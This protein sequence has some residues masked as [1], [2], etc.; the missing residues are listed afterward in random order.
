MPSIFQVLDA[1]RERPG[2]YLSWSD[3]ERA[4][5][6]R[7]LRKLL[8]GYAMAVHVHQLEE[9]VE[10]FP[11]AFGDYLFKKFG[12]SGARG[13]IQAIR[14]HAASDED[15]WTQFWKLVS[16]FKADLDDGSITSE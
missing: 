7:D 13:P 11:R 9:P 12:W 14:D 16:A 4:E 10:N 15:A 3:S 8:D 6:L 1:I 2:M 5:Q